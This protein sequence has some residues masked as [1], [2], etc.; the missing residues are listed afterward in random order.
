[1]KKGQT[2]CTRATKLYSLS[3]WEQTSFLVVL[4]HEIDGGL[5]S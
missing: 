4:E 3:S 2:L 1:M 5:V